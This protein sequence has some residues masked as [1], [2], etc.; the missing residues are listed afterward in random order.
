MKFAILGDTHFG[1]RNGSQH[2]NDLFES[3]YKET[4]IPYL[5]E[6]KITQVLQ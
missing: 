3:F 6:N 5:I 4:F 1:V 2:F